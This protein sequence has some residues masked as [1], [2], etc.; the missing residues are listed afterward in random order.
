MIDL[1]AL[2]PPQRYAVTTING[3]IMILAGA[4]TGK[5][6][7]ISYR[8]ANLIESGISPSNIVALT[9]TRKA[10]REMKERVKL[11]AGAS[12][13][14]LNIG[15]FHSFCLSILRKYYEYCG[16]HKN[17]T[18]ATTSDQ[19]DL[20]RKALE[21]TKWNGYLKPEEVLSR[22]SNAKNN[23]VSSVDFKNGHN[24]SNGIMD[25]DNASLSEIYELYERQ[26]KLN[27]VVDYDDC[28]FKTV[29][30]LKEHKSIREELEKKLTHFLVDEFQDTNFSQLT[31]LEL[32]A[33]KHQ[34]IC[35]VGD[36]DQSIYSW[37]GALFENLFR[38]EKVFP[39][40]LTIKLE[41]NYRCTNTILQ[42]ANHLIKNN[43]N[44]KEKS[45]WSNH[46]SSAKIVMSAH[47]NENTEAEWIARKCLSLLGSGKRLTDIAILYRANTQAKP[48]ELALRECGLSYRIFGGLSFFERKEIKDFFAYLK[49]CINPNDRLA[50]WRIINLPHRG[51]GL[52]TLEKIEVI[53][54]SQNISP[55]QVIERKLLDMKGKTV[56]QLD[57]FV[58]AIKTMSLT[59][60]KNGADIKTQCELIIKKF[61]LIDDLKRTVKDQSSREKK[62]ESLKKIPSWMEQVCNDF[63][64][65]KDNLD[66]VD[67]IDHICLSEEEKKEEE[68]GP[69]NGNFI[70]LMTIHGAKGLEFSSVFIAG[71]EE[72]LL[73]HRN[74]SMTEFSI[75]EERRIFYVGITRAK[76]H[77]FLSRAKERYSG[78]HKQER[79]PSR[80]LLEIPKDLILD[81]NNDPGDSQ[82]TRE[83]KKQ[84]NL[85]RLSALKNNI[86]QGFRDLDRSC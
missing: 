85:S 4:G 24:N 13:N 22:I 11:I 82:N 47:S 59:K 34:N 83:E 7:V 75:S 32:L 55:F 86:N 27:R 43:S 26:L 56:S 72:E 10:A 73:P 28:I 15:T 3:S 30:V 23:L 54:N 69:D 5:T 38:F 52:K 39:H 57:D 60:I 44:R 36:D 17:F 1:T 19:I 14:V 45:L 8:I 21:E 29:I 64:K 71:L 66:I 84:R 18:I 76:D 68:N 78:N 20:V 79:K 42:A 77:L 62:V 31:I 41:Q 53:S 46:N 70:S 80:F 2:N 37:R 61:G 74:S 33:K 49:L 50:F 51:I 81:E 9:F 63:L 67:F 58:E 40:T 25:S 12:A 35:I 6:R 48:I 16:L 65:E